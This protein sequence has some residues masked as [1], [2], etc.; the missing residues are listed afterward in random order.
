MIVR[1]SVIFLILI[2][3]SISFIF[4][5]SPLKTVENSNMKVLKI[6]KENKIITKQTVENI[7]QV[8]L[9]VSDFKNTAEKIAVQYKDTLSHP[10]YEKFTGIL[11]KYLILVLKV[12]LKKRAVINFEYLGETVTGNSAIVRLRTHYKKKK[13]NI[14]YVLEKEQDQWKVFNYR[15]GDTD[16]ILSYQKQFTKLF[17]RYSF[18]TI[19]SKL[20]I[21]ITK[22]Q[23]KL[24]DK[25][26]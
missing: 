7:F 20:R 24:E 9:T 18:S 13:I 26:I 4:G 3:F 15:I 23:L 10:D 12:R 19:F 22:L 14:D 8:I 5:L 25:S 11:E 21:K 16:S 6:Y 17:K 1:R 2:S